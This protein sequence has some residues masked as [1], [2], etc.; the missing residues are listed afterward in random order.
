MLA[1][2]SDSLG[3]CPAAGAALLPGPGKL[4]LVWE[5]PIMGTHVF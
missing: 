4:L 1:V 5:L 3:F 2:Q